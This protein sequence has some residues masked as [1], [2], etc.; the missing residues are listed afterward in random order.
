M[1]PNLANH[2]N[3]FD[4][5]EVNRS[6]VALLPGDIIEKYK[7]AIS[8]YAKVGFLFLIFFFATITDRTPCTSGNFVFDFLGDICLEFSW[9]FGHLCIFTFRLLPLHVQLTVCNVPCS[10]H[11]CY[12]HLS[13]S[14]RYVLPSINPPIYFSSVLIS[15]LH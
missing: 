5:S 9:I 3:G 7:E 11:W 6:K 2:S 8:H 13:Q 10:H 1:R 12:S 4:M 14:A 15:C